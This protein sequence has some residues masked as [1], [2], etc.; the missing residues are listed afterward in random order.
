[1][2]LMAVILEF[3]LIHLLKEEFYSLFGKIKH[4]LL[5]YLKKEQ[6]YIQDNLEDKDKEDKVI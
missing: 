6:E 4:L 1:M 2:D 5:N 3:K